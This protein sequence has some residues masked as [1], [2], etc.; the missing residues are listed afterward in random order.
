MDFFFYYFIKIQLRESET[1]EQNLSNLLQRVEDE[2]N[3]LSRD[4]RILERAHAKK[5]RQ[6]QNLL[7]EKNELSR[8]IIHLESTLH[9]LK[10]RAEYTYRRK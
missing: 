8:K 7:L 5:D 10:N 6:L 9:K 3:T 2:Y 1:R 4:I